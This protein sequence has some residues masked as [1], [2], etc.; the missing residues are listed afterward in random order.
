M[1]FSSPF[2]AVDLRQQL[3]DDSGLHVRADARAAG[4]EDR[5]HLVEEHDHRGAFGRLLTG[6]LEDQPDV[7]L[8]LADELVEQLGALDVEEVRLRLAGVV[9]ADLGH[10]LG[11]RVRD[12]LGD[13]RLAAAR[14]AVQQ[15]TLGRPQRV[16]AVELLVQ[17]RQLDGV[18][19]LL[20]LPAQPA[21]VV[22]ADVG[23]LFE[24]EILDL[25][26]GDALERV[27]R[28]RVDEQRVAG[29]QLAWTIVV[30]VVLEFLVLLGQKLGG[31]QRLGQPDDALLVGM[32]RR[33]ARGARRKGS[34][35]AC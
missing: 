29:A 11:Q 13:Q 8:G 34:R 32:A 30:V 15:H 7:T 16:L 33:R 24:N 1:T 19:D 28:L 10:L 20:D 14:R 27:S 17:E 5:V 6:T 18:A 35:A 9:A 23:H 31:H 4:A 22:V 2:H 3:R 12:R 25:G 21:D 26:L